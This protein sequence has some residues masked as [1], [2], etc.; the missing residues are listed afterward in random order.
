MILALQKFEKLLAINPLGCMISGELAGNGPYVASKWIKY[1]ERDQMM[2]CQ[3]LTFSDPLSQQRL[4]Q[5]KEI[6]GED[7]IKRMLCLS[8]FLAGADRRT[9]SDAL[10]IPPGTTRSII[11]SV[12]T[13]GMAG[14][15]DRR[16]K[17]SSFL[18]PPKPETPKLTVRVKDGDLLVDLGTPGQRLHLPRQNPIQA[19]AVLLALLDN[20]LLTTKQVAEALDL[21]TAQTLNLARKV[22]Q[23]DVPG[24]I[25]KRRGQKED[26]KFTPQVK[27]EVIQQFAANVITGRSSSGRALSENLKERCA[28]ILSPRAIRSH[29]QKM[30][31]SKIS[32]TLPGLVETQ[33]KTSR[34]DRV[35]GR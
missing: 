12:R 13:E 11:R 30:G 18:P 31:L 2:N 27:A 24:L 21:S 34:H 33:K 28:L 3:D 19:K 7:C 10:E 5:F 15:E 9:L 26:Y 23:Q 32:T 25:D 8:L 6:L 29:L 20:G 35:P 4:R 22:E 16:R 14:L 1:K 17:H